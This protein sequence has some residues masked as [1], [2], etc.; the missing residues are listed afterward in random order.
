MKN[1]I[2]LTLLCVFSQ[3]VKAQTSA[4]DTPITHYSAPTSGSFLNKFERR[5]L[6]VAHTLKLDAVQLKTLDDINDTY[7][8]QV[9]SLYDNKNLPKKE[10]KAEIQ[11]LKKS[12]RENFEQ[13]LAPSQLQQWNEMRKSKQKKVFR[14]K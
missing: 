3:A 9:A 4:T 6:R 2:I 10:R 14:K 8:T 7:V 1:F 5:E 11:N 13:M 12:R